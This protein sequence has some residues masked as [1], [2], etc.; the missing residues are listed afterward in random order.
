MAFGGLCAIALGGFGAVV[1]ADPDSGNGSS[2][3]AFVIGA[4]LGGVV[5][6]STGWLVGALIQ[7]W[8]LEYPVPVKSR[9]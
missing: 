4:A 9:T 5:C 6:W 7:T 3:P 1:E 8:R 2:L